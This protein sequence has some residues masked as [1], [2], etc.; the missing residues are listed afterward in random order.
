MALADSWLRRQANYDLAQA[1]K[2]LNQSPSHV[3]LD[4][5]TR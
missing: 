2:R 4:V 1:R 5:L 3:Q